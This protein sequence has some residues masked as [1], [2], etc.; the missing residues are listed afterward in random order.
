MNKRQLMMCVFFPLIII[1]C[2]GIF[3][4]GSAKE[5]GKPVL[6]ILCFAEAYAIDEWVYPFEEMYNCKI[7]RTYAGTVEEHYSKT[8]AAP[9]QYNIVSI[10]SSRVQMYYDDDLIQP[11]PVEDLENWEKLDLFFREGLVE[12]IEPGKEFYVPIA[13]G[14]QDFIVNT[15]EIGDDL[16][17]YLTSIGG[18]RYTLTYDVLKA[19]K[20]KD[21]TALFNEAASLTNM[22]AIAAGVEDPMNLSEADYTAMEKELTAWAKNA[23]TFTQG[24]DAEKSVLTAEDAYISVTGN[25]VIQAN[26]LTEEGYGDLF[27]HFLP[28]EGTVLWVDGWV[29]TKPTEGKAY[30][31]AMKYIDYMIGGEVQYIMSEKVGW[32]VVNPAGSGGYSDAV[33]E[34]T[35]WY[36]L[37]LDNFPVPLYV[38]KGEEDPPRRERTWNE[39]KASVGF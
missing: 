12:T 24:V 29:I 4:A 33:K 20:F 1:A 2:A 13:W 36:T 32:G 26:L 38:M 27:T 23:R 39:I 18:G 35:W 7:N 17:P 15:N 28:T 8:K 22:A 3:F 30:D 25:N 37:G 6:S 14:N 19:P 31:L 21:Q 9:D 5:K 34:R 10:M 11:I 16:V